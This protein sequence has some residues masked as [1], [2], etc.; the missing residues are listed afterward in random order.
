MQRRLSPTRVRSSNLLAAR[1]LPSVDSASIVGGDLQI[2]GR[3]LGNDA[4]DIVVVLAR[5]S[6]GVAVRMF[7]V[8]T[9][10]ASQQTLQV[11]GVVAAVG[12]GE[13]RVILRVN[14]QQAKAS[15]AVTVP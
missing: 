13:Y 2:D 12:A 11:A 6:D 4:D 3:L 1:L 14:N 7:D 9:A 8:I 10:I 5:S 15:P